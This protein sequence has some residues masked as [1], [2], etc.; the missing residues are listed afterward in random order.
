VSAPDAVSPKV[1]H[2]YDDIEEEDNRL[3]NWWLFILFATMVFGFAYWYVYQT[4][5]LQPSLREVYQA[6]VDDLIAKR[7]AAN[8]TSPEA[9]LAIA[10]DPVKLAEAEKVFHATC[11]ACHG[12]KG[13]GIIGPNLTDGYWLHGKEP[14]DLLRSALE[15]F[16]AKGMPAWGQILGPEKCVQAAAYVYSLRNTNVKGKAPQGEKL[17]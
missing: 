11:A 2:V 15:G 1:V 9:L 6:Q 3:P 12:M 17:E 5:K 8:P 10:H 13:E 7:A 16:P 4:A 14:A